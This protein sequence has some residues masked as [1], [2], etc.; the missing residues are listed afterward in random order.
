MRRS[1]VK[2]DI[3]LD[4]SWPSDDM[5]EREPSASILQLAMGNYNYG[6]VSYN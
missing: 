1:E 4:Y 2:D 5:S 3:A 6:K